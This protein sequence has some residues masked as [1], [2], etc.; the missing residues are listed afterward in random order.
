MVGLADRGV[1][2]GP[3]TADLAV[4]SLADFTAKYGARQSYSVL[5]D[6]VEAFFAEGGNRV[7]ISRF[8]GPAAVKASARRPGAGTKFTATAKS[9]GAWGNNLTVGVAGGVITVYENG[10]AVET[11]PVQADVTAAQAWSTGSRYID[12]TPVGSGALTDTAPVALTGGA[13][14]RV[15]ATDTQRQAAL[16]RFA[17][18]L[19]PG[20]VLMPGDTR[21][22]AHQM[23][24]AHANANNRFALLDAPDTATRRRSRDR[25]QR[26]PRAR[27][28]PGPPLPAAR[29]VADRARHHR[30]HDAVDPAVARCRPG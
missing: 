20:Q 4:T 25:R 26:R 6:A 18:A 16:D 23:L 15:N 27:P 24:A 30:R 5:Y 21:T 7:F 29:A 28:R 22:Q 13:D 1:V 2:T 8:A 17:K 3:I 19:G 11:S 14:D 9:V 10:T 12:I